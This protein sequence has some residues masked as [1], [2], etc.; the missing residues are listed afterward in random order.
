MHGYD[1]SALVGTLLE[2]N[3]VLVDKICAA[4]DCSRE[5]VP[6]ALEELVRFMILVANHKDRRLTPAHRVDLV[7]HE[8]ILC[9]RAYCA[10]CETHFDRMIHHQ[11]GGSNEENRAQFLETVLL[12]KQSFGPPNESYWGTHRRMPD[13]GACESF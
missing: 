3:R 2:E 12:Y 1:T 10:F 9:T 8:F 13:C 6:N 11:P 5:E 7:W 4:I